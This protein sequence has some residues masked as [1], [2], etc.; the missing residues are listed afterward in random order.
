MVKVEQEIDF[1]TEAV[2]RQ[3]VDVCYM[4]HKEM[5]LGLFQRVVL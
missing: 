4:V 5:G 2:A 3:A 1:K